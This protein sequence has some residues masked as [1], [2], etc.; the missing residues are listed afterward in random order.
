MDGEQGLHNLHFAWFLYFKKQTGEI[1]LGFL[2]NVW[3][4]VAH[5]KCWC[6]IMFF[7]CSFS[8]L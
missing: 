8:P 5:L 2:L 3:E 4:T 6:Q 1:Y 7:L